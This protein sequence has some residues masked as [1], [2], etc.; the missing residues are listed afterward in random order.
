MN[1]LALELNA[2]LEDG[3][4]HILS[5]LSAVGRHLFFPKGI[6]S[7]SAE[8]KEQAHRINAT[9]GIAKEGGHTITVQLDP[10]D[11]ITELNENDNEVTKKVNVR[12]AGLFQP[13]FELDMTIVAIVG[14]VVVFAFFSARKRS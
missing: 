3:N 9:I 1:P 4:A 14:L 7:Q 6:L 12:G 11:T 10:D 5:T 8:A 2:A 13:G